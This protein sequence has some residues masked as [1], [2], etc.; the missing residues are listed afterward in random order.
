MLPL[1]PEGWTQLQPASEAGDPRGRPQAGLLSWPPT[2][3]T[4]D[5][6]PG[7]HPPRIWARRLPW[8][9]GGAIDSVRGE[10][11][12]WTCW[13]YCQGQK[14]GLRPARLGGEVGD[15]SEG[16]CWSHS[17]AA[18]PPK[19]VKLDSQSLVSW[20]SSV[21]CAGCPLSGFPLWLSIRITGCTSQMQFPVPQQRVAIRPQMGGR[22]E[23][24]SRCSPG[25]WLRR[26]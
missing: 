5:V 17:F 4:E 8:L 10:R 11:S 22:K 12:I 1:W 23:P 6:I 26:E 16:T 13:G 9:Q 15:T 7:I 19:P 3:A 20:V 14:M 21:W 25:C 24:V 18:W 2:W